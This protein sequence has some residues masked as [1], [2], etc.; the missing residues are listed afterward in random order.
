MS[1]SRPRNGTLDPKSELAGLGI[2]E[3]GQVGY[4]WDSTA[5]C[6]LVMSQD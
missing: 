1:R 4:F 6:H 3:D 2:F 5:T